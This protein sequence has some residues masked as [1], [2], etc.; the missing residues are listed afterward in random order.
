MLACFVFITVGFGGGVVAVPVAALFL[1]LVLI[2][3]ILAIIEC[4][5]VSRML[6]LNRR[7][8]V[9]GEAWRVIFGS[10][11]GTVAG[12]SLLVNLPV[13]WLMFG[14][15]AFVASFL[16]AR[17][18]VFNPGQTIGRGW[19]WP[20]GGLAGICSG[21]FGAGGPPSVIYLNL[22]GY[23]PD[24]IRATIATTG[25][26]NL[27]LRVMAFVGAGLYADPAVIRTALW[28]LPVAFVTVRIAE[29]TRHQIS[30]RRL[31]MATYGVL[32]LSGISLFLRALWMS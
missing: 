2:L 14:M 17:L 31:I 20:M 32:G 12:V 10:A 18:F 30:D 9:S 25:T 15:A 28:L 21:A 16:L 3:P 6:R 1:D 5:T 26:A 29:A 23:S 22:R 24:E 8:I 4:Y 7:K 27:L 19:A 13:R 11:I